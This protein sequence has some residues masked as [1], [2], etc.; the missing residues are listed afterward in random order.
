MDALEDLCDEVY[1][2]YHQSRGLVKFYEFCGIDLSGKNDLAIEARDL[3]YRLKR[4]R[5]VYRRKY[6]RLY[7]KILDKNEYQR[8]IF[9]AVKEDI[10]EIDALYRRLTL[11]WEIDSIF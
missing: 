7:I 8:S 10:L 2:T 11:L 1:Q 3:Y 4:L 5:H 9:A 6:E